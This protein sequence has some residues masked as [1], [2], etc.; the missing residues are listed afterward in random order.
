[1]ADKQI[2][3][4]FFSI[5]KCLEKRTLVT[6]EN[7]SVLID[8]N[9]DIVLVQAAE[10]IIPTVTGHFFCAPVPVGNLLFGIDKIHTLFHCVDQ[11]FKKAF[12]F[13]F[14]FLQ[15]CFTALL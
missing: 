2:R 6:A 12:S 4:A 1:M 11:V 13:Q 5:M 9:N 14:M 8:M 10:N 15:Y 7:F 3:S